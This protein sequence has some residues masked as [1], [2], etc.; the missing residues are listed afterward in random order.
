M[1]MQE[2]IVDR[3]KAL[4]ADGTVVGVW[5]WKKGEM[6][7]DRVPAYFTTPE[8]L[9][10]DFVYDCF[11]SPNVSRY[12]NGRKASDG[13]AM[14]LLKPCDSYSLNQMLGEHR[15]E[16]ESVYAFGIP[17]GDMVDPVKMRALG[18]RG[19]KEAKQRGKEFV[20]NTASGE[21]VVPRDDV[22]LEKC[23]T[24]KSNT[25]KI[26]DELLVEVKDTGGSPV[27]FSEVEKLEAMSPDERF[28][29]WQGELSKCIR[30]NACRNIC[31][32][33]SCVK[34]VFDNPASSV[35]SKAV[36]ES[37]EDKMFH[38]VRAF[39]VAGRCTDC[40]E[41]SRA[42]PQGIPL[43]LLNRKFILDINRVYGP[44][45]AGEAADGVSPLTEYNEDDAEPSEVFGFGGGC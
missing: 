19:L 18:I 44:F 35:A 21:K 23:L 10:A 4:L 9:D 16:R 38:I 43:H 36:A 12:L 30:C 22:A 13:K 3:A 8:E 42:C 41:C 7:G 14:A 5:G 29:F 40:G 17:T 2:K 15:L 25:H 39:H 28:K 6:P 32:V 34:C 33:C 31:P 1:G 11:C 24:C 26:Y 37:F 20:F 45:Q 27:R